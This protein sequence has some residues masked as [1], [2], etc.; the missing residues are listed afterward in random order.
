MEIPIL[1]AYGERKGGRSIMLNILDNDQFVLKHDGYKQGVFRGQES[2]YPS[3]GK[4]VLEV[5]VDLSW[6]SKL[7]FSSMVLPPEG[8][9]LW[10]LHLG[11]EESLLALTD[12][13]QFLAQVR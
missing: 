11:L 2:F 9:I 8:G 7:H 1:T 6:R 10:Q 13:G 5:A 4:N 3:I 12:E